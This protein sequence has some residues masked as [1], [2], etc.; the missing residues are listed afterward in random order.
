MVL[1]VGRMNER[2][3]IQLRA[4]VPDGGTSL[5]ESRTKITDGDVWANVAELS[6][7][8]RI[9]TVNAGGV[10][11]P[12]HAFTIRYREDVGRQHSILFRSRNYRVL[13][14]RD[15]DKGARRRLE[16]ITEEEGDD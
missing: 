15:P 10:D 13:T 5:T 16:I 3:E 8:A 2:V 4:Q 6:G 1:A 14:V 9:A 7:V 12:T 11:T